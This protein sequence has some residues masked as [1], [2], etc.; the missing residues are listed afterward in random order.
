[1]RLWEMKGKEVIN[2][3]DG[4]RLGVV[5]ECELCFDEA[6]GRIQSMLLPRYGDF[7]QFFR[8]EK[9]AA[10]PWPTIKR[11]GQDFILVDGRSSKAIE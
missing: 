11:I 5:D 2:L 6:T 10:I 8:S 7:W 3:A 4:S 9:I 1:M